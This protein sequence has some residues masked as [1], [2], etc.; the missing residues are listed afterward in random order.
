[1]DVKKIPAKKRIFI[2]GYS[3]QDVRPEYII[4]NAKVQTLL[5]GGMYLYFRDKLGFWGWLKRPLKI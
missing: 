2:S 5:L 1:V 3:R 4:G